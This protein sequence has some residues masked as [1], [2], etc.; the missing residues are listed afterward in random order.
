MV[1]DHYPTE[2]EVEI[3]TYQHLELFPA[4]YAEATSQIVRRA[5]DFLCVSEQDQ[6]NAFIRDGGRNYYILVVYMEES[7]PFDD[8]D[9]E[10]YAAE[11]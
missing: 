10:D 6:M 1:L 2:D 8:D 4:D 9:S 11:E 3:L 7:E 5:P